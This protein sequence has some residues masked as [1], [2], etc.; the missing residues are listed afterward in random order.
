LE[1]DIIIYPGTAS[2]TLAPGLRLGWLALPPALHDTVRR[3]KQLADWHS[4]ALD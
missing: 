3:G 2:K 1:P 4:G